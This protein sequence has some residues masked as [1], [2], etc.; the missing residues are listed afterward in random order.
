LSSKGT[1]AN[2]SSSGIK[3]GLV[4]DTVGAEVGELDGTEVGEPD[5]VE[6]GALD[7]G[8]FVEM[9]VGAEVRLAAGTSDTDV[10]FAAATKTVPVEFEF[11]EISGRD[12]PVPSVSSS[13]NVNGSR[14]FSLQTHGE[15]PNSLLS[16]QV[17]HWLTRQQPFEQELVL[18]DS[19]VLG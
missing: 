12:S 13:R 14:V 8:S 1:H 3:G 16:S 5:G 15:K 6:V 2:V 4:G 18:Q 7:V 9:G 10:A 17:N 19:W 11:V